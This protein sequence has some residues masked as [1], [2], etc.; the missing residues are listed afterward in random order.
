MLLCSIQIIN[1]QTLDMVI[2]LRS[3]KYPPSVPSPP[4]APDHREGGQAFHSKKFRARLCFLM[5]RRIRKQEVLVWHKTNQGCLPAEARLND[6]VGQ[7]VFGAG[8]RG[9]GAGGGPPESATAGVPESRSKAGA[10]NGISSG[11]HCAESARHHSDGEVSICVSQ[12]FFLTEKSRDP[13]RSF[14]L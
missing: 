13:A 1:I 12:V 3:Q 5:S 8:G 10:C 7:A 9:D 14:C 4:P 6:T 2:R 11:R